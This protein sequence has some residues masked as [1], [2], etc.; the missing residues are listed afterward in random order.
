[1]IIVNKD[2]VPIRPPKGMDE[3]MARQYASQI[4]ELANKA[5]SVVRD[6]EPQV[7]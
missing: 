4:T 2:G 5:R 6:L 3:Q 1:M 7:M